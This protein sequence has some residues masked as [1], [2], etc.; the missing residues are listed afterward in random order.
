M[1]N[2]LPFILFF[3][4]GVISFAQTCTIASSGTYATRV[5]SE[6]G[7]APTSTG[8]VIVL[9]GV[10]VSI[11][12]NNPSPLHTG[13]I[14]IYGT[15]SIDQPNVQWDGNVRV[16][17][18]GKLTVNEKLDIGQNVDNCGKTLVIETGGVVE[19]PDSSPS[20]K[21]QICDE[22]VARGGSG[23]CNPYPAGPTPYCQ[24]SGGFT[25]PTGFDEDGVNPALPVEILYFQVKSD[26]GALKLF[27][28]TTSE[29]D[30]G[31]F[32]VERSA[33]GINFNELALVPG[34]GRDIY[35]QVTQ[36]DYEDKNPLIGYNFYRLKAVDRDRTFEYFGI[37]SALVEGKVDVK[38]FPNPLKDNTLNYSL[39]F[40]PNEG[41]R[42]RVINSLGKEII[43]TQVAGNGGVLLM[44]ERLVGGIY[45][46]QYLGSNH[47]QT[48]RFISQ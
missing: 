34:Q 12:T 41:D 31:H 8:T 10:T 32:V 1:K 26:E 25:G 23:G 24:P 30:F 47:R 29:E 19:F 35:R 48:I 6:T 2:Y 17:N 13:D 7:L 18:G 28:A 44:N 11:A 21:L 5:C 20:D 39:N 43:N 37:K 36:Y 40:N 15:V 46:L 9:A 38:V 22:E 27:W 16:Y 14:Q 4:S 45:F 42:V 3:F 33:D